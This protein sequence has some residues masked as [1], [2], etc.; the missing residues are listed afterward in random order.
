MDSRTF[1]LRT[2]RSL[3]RTKGIKTKSSKKKKNYLFLAASA[4]N[5]SKFHL[6]LGASSFQEALVSQSTPLWGNLDF[7]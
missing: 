3:K 6:F 2:L 1:D 7:L 4:S 5:L